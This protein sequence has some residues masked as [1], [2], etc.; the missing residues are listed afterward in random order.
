ML[1]S[2]FRPVA[3]SAARAARQYSSQAQQHSG[4]SLKFAAAAAAGLAAGGY[5]VYVREPTRNENLRDYIPKNHDNSVRESV[6]DQNSLKVPL[7]KRTCKLAHLRDLRYLVR[8]RLTSVFQKAPAQ[9]ESAQE[10]VK[11]K[12][13]Q[14]EKEEGPQGAFNEETGEINWDC[15]VRPGKLSCRALSTCG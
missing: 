12:V 15:P 2:T 4:A 6:L 11:Q 13:K 7:H 3:R 14:A 5:A 10:V 1:S 8:L 9:Q